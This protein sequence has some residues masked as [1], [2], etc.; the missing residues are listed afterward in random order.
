[1]VR[2]AILAAA[3]LMGL[4]GCAAN[5]GHL[6][7]T[8]L[9]C[10]SLT[11][12][13]GVES[14]QPCLAW[15]VAADRR[16]ELQS[17]Y[18]ILVA[19]RPDLL[20][21]G[22]ADLWD[23]GV[24]RSG[25]TTLVP[26]GGLPLPSRA[27]CYWKVMSW[28][29]ENAP[30]PW[31]SVHTWDMGLL[32][33]GDW[34]AQWIDAGT[35]PIPVEVVRATYRTLD[36][37]TA[38]DVTAR[39]A[40]LVS[41]GQPV[42]AGNA[43]MGGDPKVDTPKVLDVEYRCR[44]ET[45]RMEVAENQAA[46]FPSSGLP[47]LRT[48]FDV[49]GPVVRARLYI[50]ALGVYQAWL[51]GQRIG[52]ER[53]APGWTDYRS[54]VQYQSFDVTGMLLR[55]NNTL[56]AVVGPGWFSGR[57][58]LFHAR[59]FYGQRP[60]LLAQL[61]LTYVDGSTQVVGTDGSWTR[62]DGPIQSSDIM[63]GEAF[64]ARLIV[65][66]W[67]DP[68]A[69]ERP[70]G[71]TP[72][73]VREEQRTLHAQSDQPARVFALLP[74]AR[75]SEPT[76]GHWVFDLGQNMVG[77][78][79]IH[80]RQPRG[81]RLTIRHAEVLNDDGTIYCANLRGAAATD[82][83]TCRGGGEEVWEPAFTFHGFRYVEITGLSGR[84]ALGDVTGV[85]FSSDMPPAGTFECSDP[86]INQLQSN[87][88]WGLRGNTVTI[89]TDCPQRDE[90]MGWTAD[91]QVF[92][93]TA[94]FN[95][96]VGPFL[97]K[98]MRDV[99]DAQRDDG[100]H[101]DV[102]PV[103]KGLSY[104]T[105]VWGDAGT[106]VPWAVYLYTGDTRIL[107]ENIGSM[108]RWVDW[109]EAHSTDHIRDKDRGNDYGDW[110]SIGAD[111][112]KDLIGTAYFARS[113]WIVSASCKA[114]GRPSEAAR[115][116]DLFERVRAAF[117]SRFVRAD[118]MIEGDTQTCYLL[119]LRFGLLPEGL[120]DEAARR[121]LADLQSHGWRLSTGFVGVSHLLPVL[122]D[123]GR[124]DAAYQLLQ[125]DQFP[126]WLFSVRHGATTIWERWD[127]WTPQKGMNDPGMNS[128]NHF[129]LGSCGE[130][131]FAGVAGIRP[132]PASPGF[133]HFEVRPR[134]IGPLTHAS[135]SYR[136]PHGLIESAWR[137]EG[138]VLT[139][140]V[141]VPANTT[142]QVTLPAQ[143]GTPV[144]ESGTNAEH[145]NGVHSCARS[146][147]EVTLDLGSGRYVLRSTLPQ[148]AVP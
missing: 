47:C 96:A 115:Y 129:A 142:A 26:Y 72:V 63:D 1:M 109:C 85:A 136:S 14:R 7:V 133:S 50:T 104:G 126:S 99:R 40:G 66:G 118:G 105:P 13:L 111:T 74:A 57:A 79:R 91:T 88:V 84:P 92:V 34:T 75:L 101:S 106:I 44:G 41:Q 117:C 19:S 124:A 23:S 28:D 103:M 60:A 94:A 81:T 121:L 138:G 59:A 10:E 70:E 9:R 49:H 48:G 51:N 2:Y 35:V 55:G 68:G 89:P 17:A 97:T 54:R 135:A 24:V 25:Q 122:D 22:V 73:S 77:V 116:A 82:T 61:E 100:A 141:T 107:E 90:R 125:Q 67:C 146:D 11:D 12:P 52:D 32:D 71:W 64:D 108:Q 45:K 36:G 80:A 30:G 140:R 69:A 6:R 145:A 127:G 65:P 148:H 42:V 33:Q 83:Y 113:A 86:R 93:P 58:G 139:L 102:A 130:W 128:F 132:D 131:L 5:T 29:R 120:R 31:S 37:S 43:A 21:R 53:M 3:L 56:G 46:P 95:V 144:L 27:R 119:A 112:P 110:L 114:L 15:T 20:E 38:V 87:I 18:R 78:A 123:I 98:W 39:V 16:A 76:A 147:R 8:D 134:V 137:V 143:P 4:G 62:R